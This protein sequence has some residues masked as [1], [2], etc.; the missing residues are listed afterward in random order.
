MVIVD[1]LIPPVYFVIQSISRTGGNPTMSINPY[2]PPVEVED[3]QK[4]AI[5][6][7]SLA[8][9]IVRWTVIC[10]VCAGPTLF[11]ACKYYVNHHSALGVRNKP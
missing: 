4:P 9:S 5:K 6:N 2:A 10:G 11:V 3:W 1:R 7:A 8:A